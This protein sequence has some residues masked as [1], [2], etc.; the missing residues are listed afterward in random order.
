VNLVDEQDV[1]ILEIGQQCGEIARLGDDRA[2]RGAETD[3]EFA[4]DD[5]CEGGF[6]EAGRAEEQDLAAWM[7]MRRFSRAAFW[8][9][10]SSS[11]FGRSA[12]S[13]SSG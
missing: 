4:G 11:D 6:A 3:A 5:L 13:M 12:A 1:A 9:T 2:G 7:K 8:P 10:N